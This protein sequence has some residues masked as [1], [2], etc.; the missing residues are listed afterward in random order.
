MGCV[1]LCNIALVCVSL[2]LNPK[3][4]LKNLCGVLYWCETIRNFLA[5]QSRKAGRHQP[6]LAFASL[7]SAL[8]VP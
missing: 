3:E 8:A 2:M 1:N 5:V 6:Q 4:Y 7:Q